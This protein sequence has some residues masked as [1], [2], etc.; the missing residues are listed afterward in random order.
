MSIMGLKR[1]HDTINAAKL[2]NTNTCTEKTNLDDNQMRRIMMIIIIIVG[3]G[4]NGG[5]S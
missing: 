4:E 2:E 1:R 3:Y 5:E